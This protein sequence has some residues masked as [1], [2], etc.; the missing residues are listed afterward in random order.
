[1]RS[2]FLRFVACIMLLFLLCACG[3]ATPTLSPTVEPT[4]SP[5]A[6]P[7]VAPT[8]KPTAT[9]TVA[10]TVKP[11]ATPTV[12][13]T[14]KPT[15]TPTVAP[16][17]KPTVTPTVAPTVK[18]TATPTVAPTVKPTATPTVAPTVK[19]TATPTVAPTVKPTAT[20][21]VAPTVK[22]TATP[23]VAPTVK[24]T[25]TPTVAP[26]VKPTVTPTV[27]PTV[28]PTV[29]PTVAPTVKPTATPPTPSTL[30]AYVDVEFS[31]DGRVWDSLENASLAHIGSG[32]SSIS[33]TTVV[34]DGVTYKVPAFV[35][36]GASGTPTD[37]IS[38]TFNNFI[39][40][41]DYY[42]L[43]SNGMSYEIFFKNTADNASNYNVDSVPFGNANGAGW[44]I[45]I[46]STKNG[47]SSYMGGVRLIVNLG[48]ES[49]HSWCTVLDDSP[50]YNELTHVLGSYNYDKANNISTC[51]LYVNGVEV[52]YES[53]EGSLYN[54]SG[55]SYNYFGI[56]A[57][58]VTSAAGVPRANAGNQ[59][60]DLI[61]VDAKIYKGA[62]TASDAESI[63]R[64]AVSALSGMPVIPTV[65]PT[66][67]PTDNPS[68]S[69]S[70]NTI[71][72]DTYVDVQFTS[73][74]RVMDTQGNATLTY[75]SSGLS[76][77]S[78][79]MV[80]H[81]RRTYIVPAFV[82]S[83]A[84]GTPSDYI[85]GEFNRF[86]SI[87]DY[88]NVFSDGMSYELFFKNTADNAS[89]YNVDSVP[90]G[91]AN[92]AGWGIFINS[93]KNGSSS[94]MGGARLI[95]N[96][97]TESAHK[98]CT[99]LDDSPIYNELTHLLG[100]Y[101]YDESSNISTCT[102]YV[103]G[104]EV[105]FES[106]EGSLYNLSGGSYNYFG[107][108]CNYVTSAA[109]VPR[110]NSGN[111]C[112]DLIVVDAKIYKGAATKN[113]A[114]IIYKNAVSSLSG[115]PIIP[116]TP[117]TST[118]TF[119]PSDTFNDDDVVLTFGMIS[120]FQTLATS[121]HYTQQHMKKAYQVLQKYNPD[122]ICVVGDLA[123]DGKRDQIT[124][125]SDI[126]DQYW[127]TK[128]IPMFY[129]MGN[130]DMRN[131]D[132][133]DMYLDVFGDYNF[134]YDVEDIQSTG[135]RHAI[136]NG[137]HF[138]AV[139]VE[140][141]YTKDDSKTAG[142]WYST[143]TL[144]WLDKTLSKITRENPNQYV[145]II[146]HLPPYDTVYGST[147][148]TT[149]WAWY[150]K[151]LTPILSK[152]PQ[153]MSFGGHIHYTLDA[154]TSIWQGDY[155]ALGTSAVAY[156]C[157]E[158]GFNNAGGGIA[159]VTMPDCTSLSQGYVLQV[160]SSGNVKVIR[161][162]F[163]ADKTIKQ[164]FILLA[165]RADK[166]HLKTYNHQNR[167]ANNSAPY[168]VKKDASI[169]LGA[170][171]SNNAQS[172]Q[173]S[174]T[175]ALD[176]DCVYYYEVEIY[177]NGKLE[178]TVKHVTDF[179]KA[180]DFIRLTST[181]KF[182][183]NF[184]SVNSNYKV[185][186]R[187]VDI[188]G[189]KSDAQTITFSTA[190]VNDSKLPTAYMDLNIASG[191]ITDASGNVTF[192]NKGASVS[193]QSVKHAGKTYSVSSIRISASKQ[194]YIGKF[195]KLTSSAVAT[196]KFDAGMSFE[197]FFV[198]LSPSNGD[199][200]IMCSWETGGW[201]ISMYNKQVMLQVYTG[202]SGGGYTAV[203]SPQNISQTELTH[204]IGVYDARCRTLKLYV[205]GVLVATEGVIGSY[206]PGDGDVYNNFA[207]G[208]DLTSKLALSN[209]SSNVI[210]V[211]AN[212][213]DVPLTDNQA[214]LAYT[215]AVSKLSK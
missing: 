121:N 109:G 182:S 101:H 129:C 96:L 176:D 120:D 196:S 167:T 1:M 128:S 41:Y 164:D 54:L 29:T 208:S 119:K 9:P 190:T 35:I 16:T 169:V 111:Q 187:A 202:T 56:G 191:K 18:P 78:S 81:D 168:W 3:N 151:E 67:T 141:Y 194:A 103:N 180:T 204:V 160:D 174:L 51:I 65:S 179:Y 138:L 21:T 33:K 172:A 52:C 36:S 71:S 144:N 201:G 75:V 156:T 26:T 171:T 132:A 123:D 102:L 209:Y 77:I 60:T 70:G 43:F 59:C 85:M 114:E 104:V 178:R 95:V 145:F 32:L 185:V 150:T 115:T 99:V 68:D 23:T 25:V 44:G 63:Y 100:T 143:E 203:R 4:V 94:Y 210:I 64:S 170:S 157:L 207:F 39:S 177:R 38:G 10:P 192:T 30:E 136:I 198:D 8:V 45:F 116:T 24:P 139:Q 161:L 27:A 6:T 124:I 28:K 154:E 181:Y 126:Y 80:V 17:V 97:G 19:P 146:T 166:S 135:N 110:A 148:V 213:Y 87:R 55:G 13:P 152:Y 117:P 147:R 61:V 92:G 108:G 158:G 66:Q 106:G 91:N 88:Y 93:T 74:G 76:S 211:D 137:Y 175:T 127:K 173:I 20:P 57:N 86:Y 2:Y 12:A 89:N 37:Y 197:V 189:A 83:G 53:G 214:K 193:T 125:V 153:A 11:T 195:T 47:S 98:W 134:K 49:S 133:I 206:K 131:T 130:H 82:I 105:W 142:G 42:N 40:V 84:S 22:P 149:N 58:F 186:V 72:V 73:D 163:T 62:A 215:T 31:S 188:W 34:H 183:I 205:N 118:P 14:V 199:N 7:T 155:T 69:P 50:V 15:A 140:S 5:T 90:F 159:D 122:M 165:P 46:N 112:T 162:D 200:P 107:I 48:T 79:T 184:L 212:I 113:D